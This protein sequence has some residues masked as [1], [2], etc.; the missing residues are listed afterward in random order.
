MA[1]SSQ[2]CRK[3]SFDAA[4][5]LKMIEFA[6]QNTNR[7]AARKYDV[8]EK[9]VHDWKKQK[10]QL[11]RLNSKK[12]RLDGGGPK[13]ALSDMEELVAWV[14][15]LRAQNL[16]VTRKNF[17][18]KALELTWAQGTKDFHASDGWLQKFLKRHSF[19]LCQRATVGQRLPQDLITKV[20]LWGTI[21]C[22]LSATWTRCLS[23]WICQET[24]QLPDKMNGPSLSALLVMKKVDL[25]SFFCHG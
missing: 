12:R 23:G 5:K 11:Q 4:F 9:R 6:E 22:H 25:L 21:L 1:E 16:C 8:D 24:P 20:I 17:R 18:N 15:S 2:V 13:P 7:S 10:D 3:R 14:E 19:F